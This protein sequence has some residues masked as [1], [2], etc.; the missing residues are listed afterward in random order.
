MTPL[1]VRNMQLQVQ[2]VPHS[3]IYGHCK[4]TSVEQ[5]LMH[6]TELGTWFVVVAD[7]PMEMRLVTLVEREKSDFSHL[8]TVART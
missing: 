6:C 3:L 1:T 2:M 4:P 5:V 7:H 8:Y